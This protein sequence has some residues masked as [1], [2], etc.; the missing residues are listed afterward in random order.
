VFGYCGPNR[1]RQQRRQLGVRGLFVMVHEPRIARHVSGQYRRQPTFNPDWPLLHH[2]MQPNPRAILRRM[3][4]RTKRLMSAIGTSRHFA[5]M[6][7]LQIVIGL[8]L[9]RI[10]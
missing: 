3:G 5:P 6:Q 8:L 7:N 2:G 1:F 10:M 4:D 9:K